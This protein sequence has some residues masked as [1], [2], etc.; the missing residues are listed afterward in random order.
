VTFKGVLPLLHLLVG[1]KVFDGH[2]PFDGAQDVPLFVGETTDAPSLV[3]E[4][5]LP[6]LLDIIHVPKI[7]DQDSTARGSHD[8]SLSTN[9]QSV[10]FVG[11]RVRALSAGGPWI[12][13]L[14]TRVPSSRYHG[15]GLVSEFHTSN[16]R[17][18]RAKN[19]FRGR[20]EVKRP[21]LLVETSAPCMELVL[22][23]HVEDGRRV[24]IF[25]SQR[26]V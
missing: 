15:V 2:S 22:K 18:M 17:R 4:A 12:P 11:L 13:Q 7:P 19:G 16:G 23:G 6:P 5:G 25:G 1:V 14:Y 8:K 3:L 24:R 9:G 26:V 21:D 10:H 20:V